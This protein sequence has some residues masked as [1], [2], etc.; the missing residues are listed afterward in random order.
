MT[1]TAMRGR[2]LVTMAVA[3]LAAGSW[4]AASARAAAPPT[5]ADEREAVAW[6][7]VRE[8]RSELRL[9]GEDLAAMACSEN[10]AETVLAALVSWYNANA[11]D[12]VG[13]DDAG[14]VTG[15]PPGRP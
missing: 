13:Y 8:L 10:Q 11:A 6:C 12:R 9:A 1:L 2:A 4:A 15:G 5:A 7:A 3:L 14:F